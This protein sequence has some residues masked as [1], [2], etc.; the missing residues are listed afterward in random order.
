MMSPKIF[1]LEERENAKIRMLEEGFSL[2]K[3]YGMTHASVD[4]IT[5]AVGLGKSTFY[6]FFPSKEM[7]VYEIIRYQRDRAKQ[8]FTDTLRGR[9]K[10]TVSEAKAFLKKII[11]SEDSIYQYLTA[12]DENRLKAALPPEYRI[13]PD[14]ET[15]VMDTLFAH[16][17]GV[18]ADI[19]Y[20][21]VANL[22][23][24]MALAMMGKDALHQDALQKTFLKIYELLFSCVFEESG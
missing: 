17:E 18:R 14:T 13:D 2:I 1:A 21:V 23:K 12:E 19:D 6:N 3:Q 11:F 24:I 4:K 15:T 9:D 7:F 20:K 10:M 16:M 5:K 22:I 8:F